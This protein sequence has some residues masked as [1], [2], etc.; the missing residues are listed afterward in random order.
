MVAALL[1]WFH[2]AFVW[3]GNAFIYYPHKAF[4]DLMAA[5]A[6]AVN[7]MVPEVVL[8]WIATATNYASVADGLGFWCSFFSVGT[9]MTWVLGAYAAR[10]LVRRLPVVG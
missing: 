2:N 1:T 7:A 3:L 6:S 8:T 9:G 4:Q 10:F 5:L